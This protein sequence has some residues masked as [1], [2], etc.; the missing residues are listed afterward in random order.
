MGNA[1]KK[2]GHSAIAAIAGLGAVSLLAA[3]TFASSD[4]VAADPAA[5]VQLAHMDRGHGKQWQGQPCTS[6][7]Q[8]SMQ[9]GMGQQGMGQQGMGQQGMMQSGMGGQGMMRSGMGQQGMGQQGMGQQG[10]GRQGMMRPGMQNQGMMGCGAGGQGMRAPN[11]GGL[12][13]LGARV[14]PI[15]H[16]SVDDVRHYLEYRIEMNGNKRLMLGEVKEVDDNDIV[17]D[18]TTVDGSLVQRIE[19]DRHTGLMRELE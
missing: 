9:S 5:P 19:V 7:G 14:V 11:I 8:G 15:Q 13:D 4:Q 12:P 6:A 2:F 18:I 3:P 1:M 16:L 10:M 17:A